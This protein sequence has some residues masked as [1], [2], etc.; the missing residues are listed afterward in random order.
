MT[1]LV[2]VVIERQIPSPGEA[3]GLLVLTG[4]V[5]LAVYEGTEVGSPWAVVCCFLGTISNAAMMST[6]GRLLTERIDVLR[7]TFYTAPVSLAAL[8]PLYAWQEARVRLA[9][10][11]HACMDPSPVHA[12][13]PLQAHCH[14]QI[15]LTV[16]FLEPASVESTCAP[17]MPQDMP[18]LLLACMLELMPPGP[19][20]APWGVSHK[21]LSR[22]AHGAHKLHL[23]AERQV[24][25]RT[26]G[27]SIASAGEAPNP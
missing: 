11:M 1:A 13:V 20:S 19:L 24:L 16:T 3:A 25:S 22:V 14:A 18:E 9:L 7:L 23:Q 2:A 15:S 26:D 27:G 17:D 6:S 8:L 12:V 4:G 21:S 10:C 5:M